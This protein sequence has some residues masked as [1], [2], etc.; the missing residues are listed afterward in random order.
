M[1]GERSFTIRIPSGCATW[2]FFGP[3]VA[4]LV[5][6]V[7]F[8]AW[9]LWLQYWRLRTFVPVAAVVVSTEV[10]DHG[11]DDDEGPWEPVVHYRYPAA[12]PFFAARRVHPIRTTGTHEWAAEI[13]AP[14]HP[15]QIVTAY[16]HPVRRRSAF[17][18]RDPQYGLVGWMLVPLAILFAG[19]WVNRWL[20]STDPLAAGGARV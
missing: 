19:A 2:I 17:L 20:G 9:G 16:H 18:V 14:F 1:S 4:F 7:S 13:I 12:D 11:D 5:F 6:L 8:S 15:G 10:V 3:L